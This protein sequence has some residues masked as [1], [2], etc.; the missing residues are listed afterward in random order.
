MHRETSKFKQSVLT[1]VSSVIS[2]G[3]EDDNIIYIT[4]K[5]LLYEVMKP[6]EHVL[7]Y[8]IC[9]LSHLMCPHKHYN[10]KLSASQSYLYVIEHIEVVDEFVTQ[11][12][13]DLTQCF[14]I[15]SRHPGRP[16][17]D[18]GGK[19]LPYNCIAHITFYTMSKIIL[20]TIIHCSLYAIST[21]VLGRSAA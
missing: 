21:F 5:M 9:V 7:L 10:I 16:K 3:I 2:T 15:K 13:T 14:I 11:K 8:W 1:L 19:N 20:L 4:S 18:L 6:I 12:K 17:A